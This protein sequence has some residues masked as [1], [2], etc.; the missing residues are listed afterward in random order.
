[1]KRSAAKK[2]VQFWISAHPAWNPS[3]DDAGQAAEEILQ[4]LEADLGIQWTPEAPGLRP[5]PACGG[6]ALKISGF[7]CVRCLTEGCRLFGPD[8]DPSGAK[9]NALPR[10]EAG[11]E[12]PELPGRVVQVDC[13]GNSPPKGAGVFLAPEDRPADHCRPDI[14]AEAESRYNAVGRILEYLR[15]PFGTFT[16]ITDIRAILDQEGV[17]R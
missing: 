6:E 10:R 7:D 8:L 9:W 15:Q 3:M 1:M 5:C 12:A 14:Y 2:R 4:E 11:P 16:A 13:V 17:T